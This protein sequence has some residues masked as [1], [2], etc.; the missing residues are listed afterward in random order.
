MS[1]PSP[2]PHDTSPHAPVRAAKRSPSHHYVSPASQTLPKAITHSASA[3]RHRA[4]SS[5]KASTKPA[6]HDVA[7]SEVVG[8]DSL[9]KPQDG[10][11]VSTPRLPPTRYGSDDL[12]YSPHDEVTMLDSPRQL[13][14]QS[15]SLP[16]FGRKTRSN[17]PPAH[18]PSGKS[19]VAAGSAIQP[20]YDGTSLPLRPNATPH[21]D[22]LATSVKKSSASLHDVPGTVRRFGVGATDGESSQ[23]GMERA[24]RSLGTR[25]QSLSEEKRNRSSSRSST[26]RLEN[27][28]E[29]TL[30]RAEPTST[31]RSR[32]SSHVLGLFKENTQDIKVARERKKSNPVAVVDETRQSSKE[33]N[34]YVS[35]HRTNEAAVSPGAESGTRQ[36]PILPQDLTTKQQTTSYISTEHSHELSLSDSVVHAKPINDPEIAT[37]VKE[38]LVSSRETI[39]PLS[40]RRTDSTKQTLPRRLLE[41]IRNH[42]NLTAPFHDKFRTPQTSAPKIEDETDDSDATPTRKDSRLSKFLDQQKLAPDQDEDTETGGEGE[43]DDD[44]EKEQISSALYYPHRGPSPEDLDDDPKETD[45]PTESQHA[46]IAKELGL[47][48]PPPDVTEDVPEDVGITIQSQNTSRYLHGDLPKARSSFSETT[49]SNKAYES[50]SS[51]AS[52]TEYDSV[53]ELFRAADDSLDDVEPTP[54][55]SPTSHTKFLRTKARKGRQGA[56]APLMAVELKPYDHQVGGHTTVFRFSKQAVC[57]QLSNRENEFYEVVEREHPELLRFLPR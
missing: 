57:K 31:A 11:N 30:T 14:P 10:S 39:Y 5:S 20:S 8:E 36:V 9:N 49:L 27:R 42:H 54:R 6:A 13:S 56:T 7:L 3:Q 53:D 45:E 23:A 1:N 15:S 47:H 19:I 16:L 17:P 48:T 26:G 29:A 38:E 35:H 43:D 32:K 34:T 44:F 52:D 41:E 37:N 55:A 18:S 2:A 12:I 50:G 25:G 33:A 28:I 4:E 40:L 22:G 51:S 46:T 21:G 24:E